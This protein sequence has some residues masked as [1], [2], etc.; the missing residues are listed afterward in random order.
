MVYT[1]L[2]I[3]LILYVFGCMGVELITRNPVADEDEVF[4]RL[5]DQYFPN[6]QVSML[7][8][9]QFV[10]LDSIGAIY[11]PMAQKDPILIIYFM[12]FILIVSI[13]LMNLVTAF[14]SLFEF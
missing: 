12:L 8:L 11:H 14:V 6:L 10:T 1:F 7:T 9:V 3:F 2:L 13:A 4:G 5:R